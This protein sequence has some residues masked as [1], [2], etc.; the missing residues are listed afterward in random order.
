MLRVLMTGAGGYLG[1]SLLA[2]LPDW[3]IT[4]LGTEK[5]GIILPDNFTFIKGSIT[6]DQLVY[7]L[8]KNIDLVLHLAAVKGSEQCREKP[9]E[10]IEI[11]VWGTHTL[12]KNA[13][14]NNVQRFIFASTYWVYGGT[15]EL[16]FKESMPA[17]PDELYGISKAVSEM[18]ITG[19]DIDYVILRFTNIF[20]LGSGIKHEDVV[21]NFIK[22]AVE[23]KP[24][25]V[26]GEG[27]QKLDFIEI[28]DVCNCLLRISQNKEIS[29][30]I[31]NV[32]SG[33]PVTI[34]ELAEIIK[35]T[36][37]NEYQ[38]E[39]PIVHPP[40]QV[41]ADDKWVSI[42]ELENKT[43]TVIEEALEQSIK[44]FFRDY[45]EKYC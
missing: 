19:S 18:E 8:T 35:L 37:Y 42:V 43:G 6:D 1:S 12:L 39:V 26:F 21:F 11:N 24:L 30:R 9:L 16:P 31:L 34:N 4:A 13:L 10:T 33:R 44:K 5:P 3:N 17:R 22:S 28:G 20:G 2:R 15:N 41:K 29:R 7:E 32:G 25:N 36:L 38:T 27:T 40:F 23:R 45:K 14:L